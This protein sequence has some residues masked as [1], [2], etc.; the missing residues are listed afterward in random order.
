MKR[1][2]I[3]PRMATIG[4]GALTFFAISGVAIGILLLVGA[5]AVARNSDGSPLVVRISG[6]LIAAASLYGLQAAL[7]QWPAVA[8]FYRDPDGWGLADHLGRI[9]AIDAGTPVELTL[10]CRR[11]AF[12][13]G[14]APRIQDV[15]DGTLTAG[16]LRRRLA[17]SGRHTYARV[18]T[19]L[20]IPGAPPERGHTATYRAR[21]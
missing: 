20:G 8:T 18:L 11:V 13:W 17:P 5:E 2:V 10:R 3:A 9:T 4:L 12:T 14:A 21:T 1:I 6:A 19:D 15:V 7:R 16:T